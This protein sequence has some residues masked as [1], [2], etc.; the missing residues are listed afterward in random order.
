LKALVVVSLLALAGCATQ[1]RSDQ[2]ASADD[3]LQMHAR[4]ERD[5][6]LARTKSDPLGAYLAESRV[7]NH[8][9]SKKPGVKLANEAL[10]FLGTKYRYGG[11]APSTGFDCSG[12]VTYAARQSLGL[13]LPHHAASLAHRG[14]PVKRKDLKKGDL[15]FFNTRGRRYSHVGIYLGN[16]DFVHAPRTGAKV[17][18]ESMNV[19]YWKKR[20]NGARRLASSGSVKLSDN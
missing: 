9:A 20:Y 19:S 8:Y 6:Y 16:G 5:N 12:L 10:D 13:K 18:I 17:R 15:V 11:A 3:A 2:A 4:A 14:V 7:H 1:P